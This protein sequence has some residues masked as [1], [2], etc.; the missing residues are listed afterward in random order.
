MRHTAR[1]TAYAAALLLLAGGSARAGLVV[2]FTGVGVNG[3]DQGTFTLAWMPTE[4]NPAN[5][6]ACSRSNAA[7]KSGCSLAR[8]RYR[9]SRIKGIPA[10]GSTQ[11]WYGCR[12]DGG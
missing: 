2:Q 9:L 4:G 5:K 6:S 8:Q 3:V 11:A 1:W 7:L 10:A 12:F